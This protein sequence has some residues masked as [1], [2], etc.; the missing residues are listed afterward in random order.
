MAFDGRVFRV[1]IA[2]PSDV[3]EEREIAVRVIQEW[4]DLYS[5]SRQV[6]LLPLR[7]E[8]HSAPEYGVRPQEVINRAIVDECDLLV[9]AFWTRI[10]TPTGEADSGTLEEIE[11]VANAGKPVMLYFSK[12]GVDPDSL[13][14]EQVASLNEFKKK[15]YS[16]ALVENYKSIIEFRD[17]LARQLELKV[18]DLQK[19]DNTGGP[20]VSLEFVD[21]SANLLG[22]EL[23]REIDVPKITGIKSATK[24]LSTRARRRFDSLVTSRQIEKSTI[25][26]TLAINN[27][28]SSGVR[29]LYVELAAKTIA[30]EPSLGDSRGSSGG[31]LYSYDEMIIS[32]SGRMLR[33]AGISRD[34]IATKDVSEYEHSL[35]WGALQPRRVKLIEP[36]LLVNV[37]GTDC[38]L[39]LSAKVFAGSFPQPLDLAVTLKVSVNSKQ[40]AINKFMP[41]VDRIIANLI[42]DES[43]GGERYIAAE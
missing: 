43:E 33:P 42:E 27:S 6:V 24:S 22:S 23:T 5:Y 20:S 29:N 36:S 19:A 25:P 3:E 39:E 40:I 31:L 30:G 10:G 14:L 15:T 8:T 26:I 12:V 41:D 4:N 34:R 18:R 2:S 35:E 7:W 21:E 37:G 17:K 11:R 9:G 38:E 16:N 32:A 28:G 13:D 1:L